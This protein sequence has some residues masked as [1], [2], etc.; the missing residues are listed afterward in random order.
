ML[1]TSQFYTNQVRV[2]VL[3]AVEDN[4]SICE[5]GARCKELM[6]RVFNSFVSSNVHCTTPFGRGTAY[7]RSLRCSHLDGQNKTIL[8]VYIDDNYILFHFWVL[9]LMDC[10][11]NAVGKLVLNKV[12]C[13]SVLLIANIALHS[14]L[15]QFRADAWVFSFCRRPRSLSFLA[16]ITPS[17]YM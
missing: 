15:M 13:V 6:P 7:L 9:H 4:L 8:L 17:F 5:N 1:N 16:L 14:F 12:E 2:F 10:T 11:S 3:E